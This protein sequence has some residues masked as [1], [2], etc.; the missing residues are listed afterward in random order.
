MHREITLQKEQ[1]ANA[2]VL[3]WEDACPS[4]GTGRRPAH[5]QRSDR[6]RSM[7]GFRT[8]SCRAFHTMA[9]ILALTHQ[10]HLI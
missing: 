9:V 3:R 1:K 5:M 2:Q 10:Y 8:R 4:Q 7:K 6:K